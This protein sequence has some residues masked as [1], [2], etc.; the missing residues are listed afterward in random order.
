MLLTEAS[1]RGVLKKKAVIKNFA[2]FTGKHL[3]KFLVEFARV[4]S[5]LTHFKPT[6]PFYSIPPGTIRKL[7]GLSGSKKRDHWR[8]M[9]K[10]VIH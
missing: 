4:K 3:N 7:S 6:F 5:R 8:K 9:D 10:G 1:T 2:I